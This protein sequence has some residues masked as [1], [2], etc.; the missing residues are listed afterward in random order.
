M[1][2]ELTELLA[3]KEIYNIDGIKLSYLNNE[4]DIQNYE[5]Y[6]YKKDGERIEYND[7]ISK[8][9][10]NKIEIFFSNYLD[11]EDWLSLYNSNANVTVDLNSMG[12]VSINYIEF[13]DVVNDLKQDD[14]Q[15]DRFKEIIKKLDELKTNIEEQNISFEDT[16]NVHFSDINDVIDLSYHFEVEDLMDNETISN[17]LELIYEASQI[18]AEYDFSHIIEKKGSDYSLKVADQE[19]ERFS[20]NHKNTSFELI[21]K[22]ELEIGQPP[23]K[24]DNILQ[25]SLALTE[26]DIDNHL[27]QEIIKTASINDKC[28]KIIDQLCSCLEKSN[29]INIVDIHYKDILSLYLHTKNDEFLL[30]KLINVVN[31]CFTDPIKYSH[32]ESELNK[33]SLDFD[34]LD[35]IVLLNGYLNYDEID[36]GIDKLGFNILKNTNLEMSANQIINNFI[37]G[38]NIND[39]KHYLENLFPEL[40]EK[41][42]ENK[43]NSNF[44]SSYINHIGKDRSMIEIFT[45]QIDILFKSNIFSDRQKELFLTKLNENLVNDSVVDSIF[46]PIKDNIEDKLSILNENKIKKIDTIQE[47]VDH[48]PAFNEYL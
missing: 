10:S 1:D 41:E 2:T 38:L 16:F 9:S 18:I 3:I 21:L 4:G 23:F 44:L 11:N 39:K 31:E 27:Y 46:K 37:P 42:I 43:S 47:S 34:H 36:R 6:F 32:L 14:I 48:E 5:I 25:E 26:I 15:N 35:R 13:R 8:L 28:H 29:S 33:F 30:Q 19:F 22:S 20:Y 24:F 40:N 45:H 7:I 17:Y 12:N